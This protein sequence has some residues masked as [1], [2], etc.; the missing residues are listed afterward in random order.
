MTHLRVYRLSPAGDV[1]WQVEAT[2]QKQPTGAS[3]FATV[4]A[5]NADGVFVG[6]GVSDGGQTMGLVPVIGHRQGSDG[7]DCSPRSD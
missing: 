5:A 3:Q 2:G 6:Y 1:G 7:A 4:A